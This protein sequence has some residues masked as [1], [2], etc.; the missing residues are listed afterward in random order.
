MGE[1]D[2]LRTDEYVNLPGRLDKIDIP[3]DQLNTVI[4]EVMHMVL[5]IPVV[6]EGKVQAIGSHPAAHTQAQ[7]TYQR[8]SVYSGDG[9]R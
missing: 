1:I 6:E 4:H 9:N 7:V 3:Q 2:V 5:N 8:P